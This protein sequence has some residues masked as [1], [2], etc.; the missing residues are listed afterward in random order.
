MV[1]TGHQQDN[2]SSFVFWG[3]GAMDGKMGGRAPSNQGSLHGGHTVSGWM[4]VCGGLIVD[5]CSGVLPLEGSVEKGA[6]KRGHE[7]PINVQ[8]F[9]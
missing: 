6:L 1:L 4:G 7:S 3:G 5:F 9:Y 8:R 2:S